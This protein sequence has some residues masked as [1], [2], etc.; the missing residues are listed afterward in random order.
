MLPEENASVFALFVHYLYKQGIKINAA[1]LADDPEAFLV[2]AFLLGERRGSPA[3][4]NAVVDALRE[5]WVEG[6]LPSLS[7]CLL[8]FAETTK[9]SKLRRFV[10]DKW[11]W[12]GSSKFVNEQAVSNESVPPEFALEVFKG[13]LNRIDT[14]PTQSLH[15]CRSGRPHV[16]C[17]GCSKDV[18]VPKVNP[19]TTTLVTLDKAPYRLAFCE[20]YHEHD[21]GDKC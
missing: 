19:L 2:E 17:L 11:I 13:F 15:D 3:F 5:F 18:T 12:E 20:T 16:Y 10:A 6:C 8:S 21:D 9:R 14:H 4:K 1:E 7:T